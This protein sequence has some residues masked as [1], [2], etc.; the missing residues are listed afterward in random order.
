[1][2][3]STELTAGYT[4]ARFTKD[5][6][7]AVDPS[8]PPVPGPRA[9]REVRQCDRRGERQPGAPFTLSIGAQ[10]KF[11]LF[12]HESFVRMDF[13]YQS[14]ITGC[15][16]AAGPEH[17][18]VHSPFNYT[19]SATKFLSARGGMALAAGPS[20][21]SIDNL[22]NTHTVVNY[23]FTIDPNLDG[24][25]TLLPL[26][27]QVHIPA[28][29]LW[30][31]G[32]VPVLRR[33]QRSGAAPTAP[34]PARPH[35]ASMQSRRLASKTDRSRSA[36]SCAAGHRGRSTT[37]RCVIGDVARFEELGVLIEH[38]VRE[39]GHVVAV[40]AE[41]RAQLQVLVCG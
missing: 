11:A 35:C 23:D 29:Y 3:W 26:Q 37:G 31:D 7:F 25:T 2:R 40:P 20:S 9:D 10:Y 24:T 39:H 16:P 13:E 5:S 4:D 34:P 15:S 1:M 21:R 18:A 14:A 33:P 36:R 28:A 38:V 22:L 41:A 30:G 12:E 17:R 27:R 8:L 19:L 32:D 6:G